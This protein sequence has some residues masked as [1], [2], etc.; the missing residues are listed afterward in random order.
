MSAPALARLA[1]LA[2]GRVVCS[3]VVSA[4][5]SIEKQQPT[6]KE[7]QEGATAPVCWSQWGGWRC[8]VGS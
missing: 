7:A 6:T 2:F 4:L 8:Q 5:R 3:L 1:L